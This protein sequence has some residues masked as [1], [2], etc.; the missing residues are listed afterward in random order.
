MNFFIFFSSQFPPKAIRVAHHETAASCE[1]L[2]SSDQQK[3]HHYSR[4]YANRQI[5]GWICLSYPRSY[6]GSYFNMVSSPL[7]PALHP[8]TFS[9]NSYVIILTAVPFNDDI[10][11]A[12]LVSC[13]CP[14]TLYPP[15]LRQLARPLPSQRP[16][17]HLP[18]PPLLCCRTA[19]ACTRAAPQPCLMRYGGRSR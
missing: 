17:Q 13:R 7:T 2:S 9:V 11:F 5:R 15:T 3:L 12:L 19:N 18:L 8:Q 10:A 16:C 6:F 1:K 4:L 14:T